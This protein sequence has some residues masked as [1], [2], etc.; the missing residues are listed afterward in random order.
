MLHIKDDVN[1][2]YHINWSPDCRF[3][4][5]SR[6]P[7]GEGDLTKSGTF[8]AANEIVGVYAAGWNTCVVSA[9]RTGTLDLQNATDADFLQLTSDGNSNKQPVWFHSGRK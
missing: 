9:E 3:V 7:D 1:K 2:I 4:A 6:G 5:F 8:Q